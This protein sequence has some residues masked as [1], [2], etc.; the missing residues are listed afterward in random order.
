ML[1]FAGMVEAQDEPWMLIQSQDL[2]FIESELLG[3]L[4]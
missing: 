2:S 3:T 4:K 1:F